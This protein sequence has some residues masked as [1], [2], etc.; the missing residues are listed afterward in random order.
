MSD[1]FVPLQPAQLAFDQAGIPFSRRYDDV[2]H[3]GQGAF[4]Q[5]EHVF[6]RGNGLPERWQG[7]SSFTVAETGFGLG[8]NF[9]ALW[10]AWRTDPQRCARLHVLSFEAHPFTR[11]DLEQALG[12]PMPD[13]ART[14]A[15]QLVDAWPPLLPGMHRLEFEGGAVT[16]TLAFGD[17]GRM[18]RQALARVDAF[19]LDGFSPRKNPEMWSRSLFGQLVR[20]SAPGATAATWCTAGDVRR[21]LQDAGFLV[22]RAPGFAG[23]R[24]MTTA[25]LREGL[26]RAR[27]AA[28]AATSILVI[29]GG[30]AGAGIAYA[31]ALRGHEVTIVDPVFHW[32]AGASHR[33]H[34]AAAIT[35][36]ISRDDDIRSRLSRAGTRRALQR[37][38][39]LP[40]GAAPRTCGTIELTQSEDEARER[41]RTL[42]VLQFPS[43]WV[44][45]MDAAQASSTV[46]FSVG[47]GVYFADGQLVRPE[48]LLKA[49]FDHPNIRR[50]AGAVMQ[51]DRSGSASWRVHISEDQG[52]ERWLE[53]DLIVLANAAQ[54]IDLLRGAITRFHLPKLAAMQQLAGQVSY[55]SSASNPLSQPRVVVGGVGYWLPSVEQVNV[56]GSTYVPGCSS[57]E[58]TP[59]GHQAVLAKLSNL[60][61]VPPAQL[62]PTLCQEP[63]GWAGWRAVV[64]GRLPV[65]GPLESDCG[66]WLACGYGSRGL[67]WSSLAGDILVAQ[68]HQEPQII[69]RDLLKAIAPR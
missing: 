65:I 6:I 7:V 52:A 5:A 66:L 62:A 9:L 28:P 4:G 50:I 56:G 61:G 24:H 53:A 37:W 12:R 30:L 58:V 14:L 44:R 19:F 22:S 39:S 55:F 47:P 67:T 36:L 29:G 26:G 10:L 60:L 64:Q 43:E 49:L 48:P 17:I 11:N 32:G 34:Q 13:E 8:Q 20:L 68:L 45:W 33:G 3:A 63:Q 18:A 51:L 35:P 15:R 27:L 31:L 21:S 54:T 38:G 2:Y 42:E 57:S 40:A 23:K 16:L 1:S 46:G 25:V 69:E 59:A 41:K